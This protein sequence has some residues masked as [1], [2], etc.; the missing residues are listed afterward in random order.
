[1]TNRRFSFALELTDADGVRVDDPLSAELEQGR[2]PGLRPGTPQ[3]IL[4]AINARPE[5]PQ[6][7]RY[8]FNA[9]IDGE[10]M[11]SIAFEA[12]EQLPQQPV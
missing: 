6:A 11:R 2:P 10:P 12:V 8:S 3:P 9:T 4:I 1:M 5:F 7:G